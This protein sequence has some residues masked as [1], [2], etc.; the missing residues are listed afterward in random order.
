MNRLI[1]DY[2]KC[3]GCEMC[4]MRCSLD[5]TGMVNPAHARIH[6]VRHEEEGIMMP[7]ACRHCDEPRCLAVCPVNAI[8]KDGATGLLHIDA[9]TCIGCKLCVEACLY[10]GP[11]D[12][13]R[14]GRKAKQSARI[15]VICDLCG[16]KPACIEMCPT[17]AIQ[18]T[19]LDEGAKKRQDEGVEKLAK[20][21]AERLAV[22]AK[23]H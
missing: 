19:V 11:T 10:G 14:E 8:S 1:I 5:K 6:I 15:K 4:V 9:E 23:K 18:F 17:G 13:P 3:V 22:G 7:A 16:G 20:L 2:D 12:V 21:R